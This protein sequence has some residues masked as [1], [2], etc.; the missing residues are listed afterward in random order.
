MIDWKN[1]GLDDYTQMGNRFEVSPD[2]LGLAPLIKKIV[3]NNGAGGCVSRFHQEGYS[4]TALS[5]LLKKLTD[6]KGKKIYE[7][8]TVSSE[9]YFYI[10]DDAVVD[11]S[12]SKTKLMGIHAISANPAVTEACK[13]VAKM[14]AGPAKRGYVFAI[15]RNN[16]GLGMTRI[17]Y[18]GRCVEKGNYTSEVI[19]DYDYIID[20]LKSKDPSGRVIIL[21]GPPGCG[22]T[23]MI[24]GVLMDVQQAMFVIVPPNMV[25]SISGPELLPLL[26]RTREDYGKKGPTVLI[27]EDADQCLAP[28]ES[29]NISSISAVLNLGDGIFGSLFDIRILATTNAKAK[30]LDRAIVR[31]MRLSKRISILPF[32]YKESNEI[33]KR[34]IGDESKNLPKPIVDQDR[35]K[36][37]NDKSTYSLAEIYKAARNSGWRPQEDKKEEEIKPEEE[38]D[39]EDLE[40]M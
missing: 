14:F 27:L 8:V 35:M 12:F 11:F 32:S 4:D 16:N 25:A 17:G 26:L 23:W 39:N 15:T 37:L 28:R 20:D 31:D 2:S 1:L 19:R 24:R 7:S 29:D 38:Y 22:K 5:E 9:E 6:L 18:A 30:D 36:P 3:A 40:Y 34:I 33:Y 10:W 21:D 13:E